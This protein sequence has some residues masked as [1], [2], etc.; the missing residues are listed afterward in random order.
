MYDIQ[1]L[2]ANIHYEK[3]YK[4]KDYVINAW[5]YIVLYFEKESGEWDYKLR[6]IDITE[7]KVF[8]EDVEVECDMEIANM[9]IEEY[10]EHNFGVINWNEL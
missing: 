4:D 1:Y 10:I 6:S 9:L 2:E 8:V 7:A 5:A 3:R